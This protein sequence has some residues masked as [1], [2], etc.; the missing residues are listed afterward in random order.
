MG[1]NIRIDTRGEAVLRILPRLN[2][3]V[4]EEWISDK[5]RYA[6]DGLKTQRLDRP[7]VRK[8]GKLVEVSW[9]E[10]LAAVAEQM[11]RVKGA[12]MAA[13][14][15]NLA[16]V[17]AM[18]ALKDL[19]VGA[20]SPNLECRQDG[21]H[22]D[23]ADRASYLF[24]TGIANLEQADVA[25]FIGTNIRHEAPLVNTRL[26]KA[27]LKNGLKAFNIGAAFDLTFPVEQLGDNPQLLAEIASGKHPVAEALKGAKN[28]IIIL[29][30]GALA[31]G[32]GAAVLKISKTIASTCNVVR[33]GWNGFNLLHNAAARVGALDIGFVPQA[34]G[35]DMAGIIDGIKKKEVK[36]VYLL[37]V[38]EI[39]TSY[40]GDAFVVY[41]GHHG[42]IGAHRA[43][44]VLPGAAY[45][46]KDATYVNM[47]GRV[48]QT[49]RAIFPP[50][51]AKEDWTILRA[52]SQL[53]GR[54]LPYHSLEQIRARISN[55]FA[56][57]ATLDVRANATWAAEKAADAK[58]TNE[59][60]DYPVRHFHMTDPI[61]RA[62]KTMA[63]CAE[64][65]LK[66]EQ[67]RKAA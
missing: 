50:G 48:Q 19:M 56:S 23:A 20:G 43:D 10:A 46:E 12:E 22:I 36:F 52:L 28:P 51:Q 27:Y 6:C 61:S 15:G 11:K 38:D 40:F 66:Q 39:D 59:K 30:A 21:A 45:T 17:E 62:S 2:E 34:K 58:I 7:Y 44:V 63:Q 3:E 24:N 53:T 67:E 37:G 57:F 55:E 4:N 25:L 31:R 65:A 47:E 64:V 14:A 8:N 49:R 5:T 18:I 13:I 60:F 16:D 35:R 32:D 9:D 26:R 41:Q 29:G 42:D 1:S 33:D 54:V